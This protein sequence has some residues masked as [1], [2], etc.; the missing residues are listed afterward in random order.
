MEVFVRKRKSRN[1]QK[2]DFLNQFLDHQ[3]YGFTSQQAKKISE[4]MDAYMNELQDYQDEDYFTRQIVRVDNHNY[5]YIKR[6]VRQ[7]RINKFFDHKAAKHARH[8]KDNRVRKEITKRFS[9]MW[10]VYLLYVFL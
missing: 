9:Y 8:G 10:Y 6:R 7:M 4:G 5:E 1:S 2:S 3:D